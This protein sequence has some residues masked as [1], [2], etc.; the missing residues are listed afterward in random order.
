MIRVVHVLNAYSI[1]AHSKLLVELP[2]VA[3]AASVH[4]L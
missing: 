2:G 1:K 3:A 4:S